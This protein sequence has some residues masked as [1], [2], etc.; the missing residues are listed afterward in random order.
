LSRALRAREDLHLAPGTQSYAIDAGI[1]L[2][3]AR[4]VALTDVDGNTVLDFIGGIGVGALGHSHPGF[5]QAVCQQV[6]RASI[7]SLTSPARVELVE[8]LASHPPAPGLHRVQLYSSGA[9]AVES[10]LR[11]AKSATGRYE[12]LSFWGGFHGKTMGALSLMGSD[13]KRGLGPLVPGSHHSPYADFYRCPL[14][15]SQDSCGLACVDLLRRQLRTATAGS[16]AAIIVEPIQGTAGN[17]AP[18][19]EFLPAVV[20]VAHEAGAL[21]IADEMITGLGRT[22]TWWGVEQSGAVP[23]IVTLGK[24][25]GGGYPLS[26][27]LTR[28]DIAAAAPWSRPSG[29]SSSYGGNPLAAAAGAATLRILEDEDL[30]GNAKKVGTLMLDLLQPFVERY[31]FVGHVRGQGL[32]LG[33]EL[34]EDK[35]TK[36]PLGKPAMRLVFQGCLQRGLLCMASSPS[37]RLQPALTLDEAT[38]RTGVAILQEVL[39]DLARTGAWRSA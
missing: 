10:A 30:P 22:G 16:L 6:E 13:W 28:D 12:F 39:D 38:A 14:G 8:R 26:G 17:I 29:S 23:D 25:F 31:P 19:K 4:G 32:M 37:L 34:V 1:V 9:E 7:G 36:V 18:P 20:D 11:L 27:L 24:A 21:C 5:V 35:T 15:L 33:I 2:E 3:S